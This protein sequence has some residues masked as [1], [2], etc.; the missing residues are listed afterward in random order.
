MFRSEQAAALHPDGALPL[1]KRAQSWKENEQNV[2]NVPLPKC[3]RKRRKEVV[4]ASESEP[5]SSRGSLQSTTG[6]GI[7]TYLQKHPAYGNYVR[8]YYEP[9]VVNSVPGKPG[10]MILMRDEVL[11]SRIA[12]SLHLLYQTVH[13]LLSYASGISRNIGDQ[14]RIRP[15][16]RV[17][18]I[19]R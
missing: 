6:V 19:R 3:T 18:Y 15:F 8:D 10:H 5:S 2:Q 12:G 16:T 9:T 13:M 1:P 14:Q 11:A 17:F 4:D 7:L